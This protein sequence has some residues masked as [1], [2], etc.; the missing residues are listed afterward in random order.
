MSR[1]SRPTRFVEPLERRA[2]LAANVNGTVF[3][4]LNGNGVRESGEP[5]L[6][7]QRV[8]IDVNFDG[9]FTNNEPSVLTSSSG[10]YTFV[11]RPAG[12]QRVSY[13]LPT[14]RRQ[15]APGQLFHDVSVAFTTI[16][17]RNFG[18]TSTGI[19]RGTIFEDRNGNARRDSN[20]RGL[21]GWT[22]FL[23]KDNDGKFD[24]GEKSRLTTAA[25]AYRFAGLTPGK[26]V[27][28]VVQQSGFVR[29][30]PSAGVFRITMPATAQSFS[31]RNFGQ[32]P[33]G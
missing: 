22:V 24:P 23:D 16:N 1:V 30:F 28:R 19:I 9:R 7:N 11:N 31:N 10:A 17:G 3:D 13:V 32:D 15:T 8:F 25:G 14:G 5:G 18:S 4:D 20:E 12:I 2:L 27:V 21:S 6:A 29:T 33:I 26:Y